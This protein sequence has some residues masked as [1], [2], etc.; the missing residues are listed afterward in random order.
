MCKDCTRAP[1]DILIFWLAGSDTLIK[2]PLHPRYIF[3]WNSL[4]PFETDFFSSSGFS[5][6]FFLH[7][8]MNACSNTSVNSTKASSDIPA[9]KLSAPPRLENSSA[10]VVL[11]ISCFIVYLLFWLLQ[12]F[13]QMF[14]RVQT[15]S[16]PLWFHFLNTIE[17]LLQILHSTLPNL[18]YFE[19]HIHTSSTYLI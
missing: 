18:C 2:L 16:V 12:N 4:K 8:Q 11:G 1:L 5:V 14:F 7:K 10:A 3:W 17:M 19:C 6:W 9:Y 15:F 13:H